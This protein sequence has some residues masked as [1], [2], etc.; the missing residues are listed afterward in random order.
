MKLFFLFLLCVWLVESQALE[1]VSGY[2]YM[3][4]E[5][6]EMQDDDF[7]NPGMVAVDSGR[8]L[9]NEQRQDEE[10]ACASCHGLEGETLDR[11]KIATYPRFDDTRGGL[12][13]LQ[14]QISHCWEIRL[15]RFPES[16]DAP[17]LVALETFVRHKARGIRVNVQTGDGMDV[18]LEEGEALFNTRFGQLDMSCHHC[19][20]QH[21]DQYLRGQ[22]LSQGQ[23]NGFPEY[24][25][26]KGRIT[27]VHLRL[28]ECFISFR[29][30]PFEPGSREFKL[31]ELYTAYRGN[32]LKIETPAV[33]Y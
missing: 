14:D 29:A 15:D 23:S 13:T 5:T 28:R 27:S 33:R 11:E 2:V 3:S 9:F 1:P 21:V 4:N 31:L 17:E 10:Y 19:H 30:E 7:E 25:L 22:K 26:G 8:Q 12:V 6:R 32:G 24:R 16:Y 18:L 20:L